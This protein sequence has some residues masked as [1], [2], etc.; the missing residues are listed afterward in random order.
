MY[1]MGLTGFALQGN[2]ICENMVEFLAH[3]RCLLNGIIHL[4]L[5]IPSLAFYL[6]WKYIPCGEGNGNDLAL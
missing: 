1:K 3:G 5:G 4:V 2:E 6:C